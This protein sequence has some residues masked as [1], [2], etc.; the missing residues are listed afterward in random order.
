MEFFGFLIV[1]FIFTSIIYVL[2]VWKRY[3]GVIVAVSLTSLMGIQAFFFDSSG[4][5]MIIFILVSIIMLISIVLGTILSE[6]KRK[7]STSK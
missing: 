3:L 7:K 1:G 4:W 5:L 2:N 6:L